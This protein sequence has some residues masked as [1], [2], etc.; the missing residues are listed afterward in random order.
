MIFDL[1]ARQN[2]PVANLAQDQ[3]N[4]FKFLF[5]IMILLFCLEN[6]EPSL[7]F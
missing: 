2:H 4:L 1:E 5:Q 3:I 7:A 6:L